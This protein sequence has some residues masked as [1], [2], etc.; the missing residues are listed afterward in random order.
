M[1]TAIR[2]TYARGPNFV[3]ARE[4]VINT[5]GES[6]FEAVLKSMPESLAQSW[7]G[8]LLVSNSYSFEAFKGFTRGLTRQV[9][10]FSQKE[11]SKMYEYIAERSL[12]AVYKMFFRF[13]NPAFVLKNYPKLWGRFFNVGQVNVSTAEA[14]IAVIEFKVPEIFVD[15][16]DDAC[17]G[18]SKKA[19]ELAGG[20]D[21]KLIRTGNLNAGDGEWLLTYSL[22]WTE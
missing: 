10:S 6:T 17:Y 12:N 4:Y 2:E 19:V 20:R 5:Y 13:S 11:T 14:G 15:W 18:Y 1:V 21:L 8:S 3:Y 9:G 7:K 22:K 16:L